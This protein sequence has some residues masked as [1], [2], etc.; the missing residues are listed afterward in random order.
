MFGLTRAFAAFFNAFIT[1][2][3]VV[4]KFAQAADNIADVT[5]AYSGGYKDQALAERE[6]KLAAYKAERAAR[7][8]A[9]AK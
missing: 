2:I 8:K 3:G 9:T 7:L 5:V 4:E 1:I 6:E